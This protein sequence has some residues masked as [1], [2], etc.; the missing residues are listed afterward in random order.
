M[1]PTERP[2]RIAY[3]LLHTARKH[4][5]GVMNG[6][7]KRVNHDMVISKEAFQ[8]QYI[9][10]K[11]KYAKSLVDGWCEKTDPRK[12]VF[13]DIAIAAFLIEFWKKVY[14]NKHSF[15]FRDLGCGN[16]LLVYILIKEGY[17]GIGID[18]RV[19]KSWSAY[20]TEV[21]ECLSEQII[22]PA[23]LLR[24]H[25]AIRK[26]APE[27]EDNGLI[28]KVPIKLKPQ[29][30]GNRKHQGAYTYEDGMIPS[31]VTPMGPPIGP[32][33]A[34]PMAPPMVAPMGTIAVPMVPSILTPMVPVDGKLQ[35][36]ECYSSAEL[37]ASPMV[38]TAEF[39]EN[40]FII[41]NHADEMTCWIPLL[42][43]PFMVIPCCS[44]N[45]NGEKIRYPISRVKQEQNKTLSYSSTSRYASLVDHV[46]DLAGMCGWKVEREMLRIPSTRNAAVVAYEHDEGP[47]KSI[48]EIIALEGGANRWVENSMALTRRPPRDH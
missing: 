47:A 11:Q 8:D 16:G 23:V 4:S 32:S 36:V 1:D 46:E 39:Q 26:A 42:G 34:P 7:T 27:Q 48:Y 22:I 18:A 13:E 28:F 9:S 25:P 10:L 37:L 2:I 5:T 35:M 38:N 33:M 19:R 20:P 14:E 12:H 44:H 17:R 30:Q 15:Q 40:T 3:R 45:L 29:Y 21:Q 6:Y 43:H 24:P 41:G 31:V